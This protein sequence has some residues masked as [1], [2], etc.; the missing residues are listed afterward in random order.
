[1]VGFLVWGWFVLL[2]GC[3]GRG[4]VCWGVVFVVGFVVAGCVC[5][6]EANLQ[7]KKE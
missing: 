4:L 5:F 6:A 2:F 3:G 7:L 1:V